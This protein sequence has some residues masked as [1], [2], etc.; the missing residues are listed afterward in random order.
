ML[1]SQEVSLKTVQS[2]MGAMLKIAGLFNLFSL[3]SRSGSEQLRGSRTLAFLAQ[4]TTERKG[5]DHHRRAHRE[6]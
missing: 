5:T 6:S 2:I 3:W 1:I 4:I